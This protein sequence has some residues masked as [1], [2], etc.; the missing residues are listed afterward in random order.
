L[1]GLQLFLLLDY[2]LGLISQTK[3]PE[4]LIQGLAGGD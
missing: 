3:S 2:A 1:P 4:H